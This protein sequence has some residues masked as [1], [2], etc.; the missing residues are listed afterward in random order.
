MKVQID[1][2]KVKIEILKV[3]TIKVKIE[4]MKVK[5]EISFLGSRFAVAF[6][7]GGFVIR[8]WHPLVGVFVGH[9]CS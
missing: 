2:L 3:E 5:I 4:I 7:F 6:M 1:I 8:F 9:T